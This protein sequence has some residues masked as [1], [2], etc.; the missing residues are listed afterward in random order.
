MAKRTRATSTTRASSG[1]ANVPLPACQNTGSAAD[2]LPERRSLPQLKQAVQGC[3]GCDLYCNATQA[4]FGEGSSHSAV[5][6]VGEQPGDQEDR[7]GKPFVGPSGKMLDSV[8][9]EVG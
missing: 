5:M 4:V 3:R 9:E 7:A 2:F 6:F 8:L 1:R